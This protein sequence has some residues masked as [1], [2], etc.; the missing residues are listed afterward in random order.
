L[1]FQLNFVHCSLFYL[2]PNGLV[3]LL[4]AITRRIELLK[5][6]GLGFSS[7][8][9]A[10]QL[11][12]KADCSKRT[13]YQ[14]FETR[15]EWQPILQSIKRCDEV[16]MKVV[17]RYEQIYREASVLLLTC[18]GEWSKIGAL[19]TMLKANAMLFQTAVLPEVMNRLQ[20]LEAR[21]K[22]GVF[23]P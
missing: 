6:E 16:L 5:L 20:V 13:I 17:N 8:E 23:V 14:D 11:S 15:T 7:A 2:K 19:N 21:A 9:I 1:V 22:H 10:T 18:E 4:D 12:Q 3:N